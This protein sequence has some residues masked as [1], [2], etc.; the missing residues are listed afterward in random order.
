ML[1]VLEMRAA[2]TRIFFTLGTGGPSLSYTLAEE[3]EQQCFVWLWDSQ[4]GEA[5]FFEC[6]FMH[7]PNQAEPRATE[8]NAT[9][10]GQAAPGDGAEARGPL[11]ASRSRPSNAPPTPAAPAES[12][13]FCPSQ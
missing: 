6:A 7:I 1:C 4:R 13:G 5:M 12:G 10:E 2:P 8:D 9:S 11:H 3:C